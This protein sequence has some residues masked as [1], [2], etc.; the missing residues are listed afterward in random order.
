[1]D[2]ASVAGSESS[3]N[4]VWHRLVDRARRDPRFVGWVL[5]QYGEAH[6]LPD[7]QVLEWLECRPDRR[8]QLALCRVP[9]P[10]EDSFAADV[11]KVGKFVGC[12]A[13]RLVQMLREVG[14]FDALR[15]GTGGASG[16]GLLMAARDRK[17]SKDPEEKGS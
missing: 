11:Q 4:K 15:E 9:D 17:D 1:M 6:S 7:N 10:D 12:N 14:A 2:R 8:N 16:A 3:S 13:D 5:S